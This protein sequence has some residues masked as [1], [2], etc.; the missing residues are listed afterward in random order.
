VAIPSLAKSKSKQ[1]TRLPL[2]LTVVARVSR[3]KMQ[4]IRLPLQLAVVARVSRAKMQPIRLP[5]Q[6]KPGL[7]VPA[8]LLSVTGGLYNRLISAA[9]ARSASHPSD[10]IQLTIDQH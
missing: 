2:Q 1:P 9:R 8:F 5:L 3:A 4:P 7:P 6:K 10:P